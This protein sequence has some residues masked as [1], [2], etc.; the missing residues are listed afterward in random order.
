MT[1]PG[2]MAAFGPLNVK[3]WGIVSTCT[4]KKAQV[5]RSMSSEG[6]DFTAHVSAKNNNIEVCN[7]LSGSIPHITID[8]VFLFAEKIIPLTNS[9]RRQCFSC[10]DK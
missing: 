10:K 5:N 9:G 1:E 7:L 4:E 2:D 6:N 8:F 3:Q